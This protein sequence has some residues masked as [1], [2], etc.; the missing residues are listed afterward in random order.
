[1]Y[2]YKHNSLWENPPIIANIYKSTY[3]IPISTYVN[4]YHIPTY[5]IE[6]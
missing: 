1:M 6:G 3:P 4:L 2:F 5:L